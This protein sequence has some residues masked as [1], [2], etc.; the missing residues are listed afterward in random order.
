MNM[1]T[2]KKEKKQTEITN[3]EKYEITQK[4]KD[5]VLKIIEN[6]PYEKVYIIYKIISKNEPIYVQEIDY[7]INILSKEPFKNVKDFFD[8]LMQNKGEYLREC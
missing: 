3:V 2:E 5:D 1:E 6:L 8:V 7:I 4:F